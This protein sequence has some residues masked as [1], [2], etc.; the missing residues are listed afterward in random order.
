MT[1]DLSPLLIR[2]AEALER[3][4]P[5]PPEVPDFSLAR[6]FRHDAARAH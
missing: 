4:A 2:I 1:E 3:L 6:L 5:S